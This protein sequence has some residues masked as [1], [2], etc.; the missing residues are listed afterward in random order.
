MRKFGF[1]SAHLVPSEG[2]FRGTG[3]F[4]LLSN[5]EPNELILKNEVSQIIAFD[6][7][8]KNSSPQVYPVSLMGVLSVIRQ[9]ILETKYANE[10]VQFDI[11]NQVNLRF[12]PHIGVQALSRSLGEKKSM[13]IWI[14]PGSCLMNAKAVE[15]SQEFELNKPVIIATGDEWRNPE[16]SLY[17][18]HDYILPMIFPTIPDLP[19][20]EDW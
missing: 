14:E 10:R 1:T 7:V 16:I 15:I 19:N 9:S 18:H 20:P 5:Q 4:V 2:I 11:K 13:P 12:I 17:P 8:G 6:P 3:P